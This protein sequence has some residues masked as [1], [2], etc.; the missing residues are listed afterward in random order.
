MWRSVVFCVTVLATL[1]TSRADAQLG[2]L[3]APIYGASGALSVPKAP[4]SFSN[5]LVAKRHLSPAGI[6]CISA[7]AFSLAQAINKN[8]YNHTLV[9][10]N[11]CAQP[12]RV[13]ACYY[14]TQDCITAAIPGY[15]R[16]QKILGVFPLK[17]FRFEVREYAD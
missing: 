7:S 8:I 12:I 4:P 5:P 17:D 2:R 3:T 9:I 15:K 14:D 16:E 10:N 1:P 6:G 11:D 13:R